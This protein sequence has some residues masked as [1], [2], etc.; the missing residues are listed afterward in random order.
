MWS[1][2]SHQGSQ[3]LPGRIPSSFGFGRNNRREGLVGSPLL[4]QTWG[5]PVSAPPDKGQSSSYLQCSCSLEYFSCSHSGSMV[6]FSAEKQVSYY[7]LSITFRH[8]LRINIVSQNYCSV[9]VCIGILYIYDYM[10]YRYIYM[11]LTSVLYA[12]S[13]Y[14]LFSISDNHKIA[15][16][17]L[18]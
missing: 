9:Y 15:W 2:V 6:N 3:R 7:L 5:F 8:I 13:W 4:P 10:C 12:G 1:M 16:E 17:T 18:F 11:D 14:K